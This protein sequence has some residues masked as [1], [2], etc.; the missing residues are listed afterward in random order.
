MGLDEGE[1]LAFAQI[2]EKVKLSCS[3]EPHKGWKLIH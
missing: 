1:P 2:A 3:S